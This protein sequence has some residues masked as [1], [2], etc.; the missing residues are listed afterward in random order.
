MTR[1][2]ELLKTDRRTL[3]FLLFLLALLFGTF[4]RVMPVLQ[5][6]F[7]LNDGGLFYTMTSDL[8]KAGYALPAVTTYN[9]LGI[10]YAYPP[11]PFYLAAL[12]R[13]R[14]M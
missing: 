3:T 4:V 5:A 2:G 14:R 6:G 10:P 1:P 12:P 13:S 7:P 11:L 8:Q 9:G